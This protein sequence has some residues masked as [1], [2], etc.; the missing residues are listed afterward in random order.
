[1]SARTCTA[2]VAALLIWGLLLAGGLLWRTLALVGEQ[3]EQSWNL[4]STLLQ[5][6]CDAT[7]RSTASSFLGLPLAGWGV[8][9][10]ATLACLLLL[11]WALGD[12]FRAEAYAA[13]FLLALSGS[14]I[15]AGLLV[16]L[17]I[18]QTP[19]CPLCVVIHAINFALV[20]TLACHPLC[21]RLQL[22]ERWQAGL[23]YLLGGPTAA[24][25]TAVWKGVTFLVPGLLAVALYQWVLL[26]VTL[27]AQAARNATSPAA[28]IRDYESQPQREIP[29]LAEDPRRGS[30]DAP[31]QLVVFSGF[32][33]TGCRQLSRELAVLEEHFHDKLSI[34]FKHFPL[35][36]DCNPNVAVDRHPRACAA[37]MLAEAAHRQGQ[38]WSVHNALFAL[39]DFEE[40]RLKQLVRDVGLDESQLERDR[41]NPELRVKIRSDA[42]LGGQLGVVATPTVYLNNRVVTNLDGGVL[43]ILI[44]HLL[45]EKGHH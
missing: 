39:A 6:N 17:L 43:D 12:Q 25:F 5:A 32:T 3:G 36:P 42:A 29:I 31:V 27:R 10:Y 28:I 11:A 30:A 15:S 37:A 2:V 38:F 9:F 24:P 22:L 1:M 16:T 45:G 13:A 40:P 18:G 14:L 4:C 19:W 34:V 33:C 35:S 20:G 7:L 44:H 26:E 41:E 23:R 21:T 8:V